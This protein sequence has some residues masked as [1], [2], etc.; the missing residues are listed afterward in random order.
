MDWSNSWV[1]I[2][3]I[4]PLQETSNGNTYIVAVTDEFSKRTETTAVLD[5]IAKSEAI[6]LYS[7]I[8]RL[9]CMKSLNSEQGREFV[10]SIIDNIMGHFQTDHHIWSV[11]YHPQT[12]SQ[13]KNEDRTLNES[14]CKLVND[15]ENNWDQV[16]SVCCLPITYLCTPQPCALNLM[17]CMDGRPSLMWT[18]NLQNPHI[19]RWLHGLADLP[20][21]LQSSVNNRTCNLSVSE[22]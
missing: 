6:F 19:S 11:A 14:L 12:D 20:D 18:S 21:R 17:S 9:G 5:K 2:G 7:V 15:Q 4:G 1:G 13:W 8:C 22:P 16:I 10:N 3:L